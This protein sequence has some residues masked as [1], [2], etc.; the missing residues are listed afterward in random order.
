M[1]T[2]TRPYPI[3]VRKTGLAVIHIP[4]EAIQHA[5]TASTPDGEPLSTQTVLRILCDCRCQAIADAAGG[6]SVGVGRTSRII[7]GW[8]RRAIRWRDQTCRFP[9]CARRHWIDVHHLIH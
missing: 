1:G 8:L 3:S 5:G 2:T 4:I 9:G 6:T 7:P